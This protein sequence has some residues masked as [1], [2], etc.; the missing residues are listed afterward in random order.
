MQD[1]SFYLA[2]QKLNIGFQTLRRLMQTIGNVEELWN[3]TRDAL[4]ATGVSDQFINTFLRERAEINPEALLND[5]TTPD[6]IMLCVEDPR[7]PLLLREIHSPPLVL[8]VR[9]DLDVL[10]N[11]C[12][13]VVGT[14]KPTRYGLDATRTIA[15]PLAQEGI[16]IVSGLA[17]GID[18]AAHEAALDAGGTTVAVL[19]SGV[20]I[21]YPAGNLELA[22]RIIEAG[23]AIVSEYPPGTTPERFRFPQRNRIIAGLSTTSLIVEAGEKSGALITAR[24][25]LDENREVFAV[26]GPINAETSFGPNNLLKMGASL[27]TTSD[28]LREALGLDIASRIPQHAEVY[29]DTPAE[30]ELLELL[31]APRHV[32]ELVAM[33]TLTTSVV[34]A[35]LS[36]LEMKG[37][38]RHLGGMQY[39]RN[40]YHEEK[41]SHHR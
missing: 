31:R 36:M 23:G 4:I 8:F 13:T 2:Y 27:A 24:M 30:N 33:S 1:L 15:Q 19:G 14:R 28:D 10:R 18:A 6:S 37:M 21:V 16:T 38:V 25:A 5:S 40:P 39:I 22:H 41:E 29:G 7:Y 32:D 35:T 12:L 3:A 11:R 34:N 9:G 17:Y 26:P 20:D